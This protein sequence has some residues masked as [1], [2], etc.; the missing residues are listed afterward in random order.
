MSHQRTLIY[1]GRIPIEP[2]PHTAGARIDEPF[3]GYCTCTY[4][5]WEP[6]GL[7]ACHECARCGKP[8]LDEMRTHLAR[9]R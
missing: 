7:F 6:I 4:P 5:R 1:R 9:S 2:L 3:A 8:D